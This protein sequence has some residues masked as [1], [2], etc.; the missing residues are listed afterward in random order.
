MDA[1]KEQLQT[2]I[3]SIPKHDMLLVIGEM[4]AKVGSI[5]DELEDVMGTHGTAVVNGNGERIVKVRAERW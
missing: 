3:E 5:N 2:F 1:V 4:N